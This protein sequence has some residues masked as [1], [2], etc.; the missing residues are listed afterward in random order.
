[1]HCFKGTWRK[2]G[3]TYWLFLCQQFGTA[4]SVGKTDDALWGDAGGKSAIAY[5]RTLFPNGDLCVRLSRGKQDAQQVIA[6]PCTDGC[7]HPQAVASPWLN[8]HRLMIKCP[9]ERVILLKKALHE[10]LLITLF[11]NKRVYHLATAAITR[12]ERECM[13]FS[14]KVIWGAIST[15]PPHD[16]ECSYQTSSKLCYTVL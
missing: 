5:G 9:D 8:P 12:P 7:T 10:Q 11:S 2:T 4:G 1:M 3:G 14:C 13:I 15:Q 6:N 16:M